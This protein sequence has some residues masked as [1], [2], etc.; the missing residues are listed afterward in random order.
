MNYLELS[1]QRRFIRKGLKF[2]IFLLF[3]TAS[4]CS[5]DPD[6]IAPEKVKKA[7]TAAPVWF[8][9]PSRFRLVDFEKNLPAHPFFDLSPYQT[10]DSSEISYYLI[11]PFDSLYQYRFDLMSGK[12][13]LNDSFCEQNDIWEKYDGEINRPPFAQGIVPRLLDQTGSPQEIWVFGDERKLPFNKEEIA[14]ESVRSRVVGGVVLKYCEH[15]PCRTSEEW[16]SRL[17]LVGVNPFHPN[18]GAVKTLAE[19]KSKVDWKYV[20]AFA[21]NGFGRNVVGSLE[22]PTYKVGG[23]IDNEA[24]VEFAFNNGHE[25]DMDEMNTLRRNC[26]RL[27]D[28]LWNGQL[29]ARKFSEEQKPAN[30]KA[31]LEFQRRAEAMKQVKSFRLATVISTST[32]RDIDED[33]KKDEDLS[34]HAFY[35]KFLDKYGDRLKTCFDFVRPSNIQEDRDRAWFFS[36]IQNWINLEKLG[37]HYSCARRSWM[38]NPFIGKGKRKFENRDL[39]RCSAR[40]LDIGF[41]QGVTLMSG[42]YNSSR[43]HYRF[44]EYDSRIGGTHQLVFNWVF[45]N[46]K[47]FGCD[48]RKLEEKGTIFPEDINWK[49]FDE[50][51]RKNLYDVIR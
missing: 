33:E 30:D 17:I 1:C 16:L 48:A 47:K 46:G 31:A 36:F 43:Q 35:D 4:S 12:H 9:V 32:E 19:L 29:K 28:Y 44:I 22:E 23:Q 40:D 3:T 39:Q 21:E 10:K 37:Y 50:N 15:Y 49:R 2:I 8:N 45:E 11:T 20:M 38:E 7:I 24:V 26:F 34:F 51:I 13:Y 18:L 42:L 14:V 6:P 27:Y 25:F 5:T 41:D